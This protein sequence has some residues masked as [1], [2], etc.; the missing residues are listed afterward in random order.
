MNKIRDPF[1]KNLL[2]V[3]YGAPVKTLKSR[4]FTDKEGVYGLFLHVQF[5]N[6]VKETLLLKQMSA[7]K[8]QVI[9][10]RENSP[11][12]PFLPEPL[13]HLQMIN[14]EHLFL[15]RLAGTFREEKRKELS[16]EQ[17]MGFLDHLEVLSQ[18][19]PAPLGYGKAFD[20][21]AAAA[22]GLSGGVEVSLAL[23]PETWGVLDDIPLLWDSSSLAFHHSGYALWHLILEWDLS[24]ERANSLLE[25]F[26]AKRGITGPRMDLCRRLAREES[27]SDRSL[28]Q[29][30]KK[31]YREFYGE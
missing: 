20:H 28:A 27:F 25:G 30:E 13:F 15:Q 22:S 2:Q 4:P 5:K 12:D 7:D 23:T 3:Y 9:L 26:Y 1:V 8:A 31:Y 19:S 14:K 18:R 24:P 6:R 11:E 21:E 29:K 10:E 16:P 17:I